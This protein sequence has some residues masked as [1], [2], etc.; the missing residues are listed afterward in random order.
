MRNHQYAKLS[1]IEKIFLRF[2]IFVQNMNERLSRLDYV[3]LQN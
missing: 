1:T 2:N 3:F